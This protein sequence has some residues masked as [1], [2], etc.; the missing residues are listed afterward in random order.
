MFNE[1][2]T[3]MFCGKLTVTQGVLA[4]KL[5]TELRKEISKALG[6]EVPEDPPPRGSAR[7]AAEDE[8]EPAPRRRRLKP[9]EITPIKAVHFSNFIIQ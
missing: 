1:R 4:A 2:I 7:R 6:L 8:D 5:A 3:H 9:E